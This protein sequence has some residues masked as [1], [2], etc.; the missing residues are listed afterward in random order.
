MQKILC[1]FFSCIS[2]VYTAFFPRSFQFQETEEKRKKHRQ[3][4]FQLV[5]KQRKD[6]IAKDE[7]GKR[8]KGFSFPLFVIVC[9]I[10]LW[11][12]ESSERWWWK[13]SICKISELD[14]VYIKIHCYT[15]HSFMNVR[16]ESEL[17]E[18]TDRH[19]E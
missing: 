9:S 6:R 11:H 2:S 4:N 8:L 1:C 12:A 13:K 17:C 14:L 16:T 5:C 15:I 18:K 7:E 19:A 10:G 3:S